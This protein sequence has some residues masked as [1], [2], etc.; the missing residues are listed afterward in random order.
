MK[1]FKNIQLRPLLIHL[2]VTLIYPTVKAFIS[3]ANRLH[4]FCDA[5]TIISGMLLICGIVY[6]LILHGD[7]ERSGFVIRRGIRNRSNEEDYGVYAEEKKRKREEAFNYPLFLGFFYF[8]VAT[9]IAYVF[10]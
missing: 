1:R 7:F 3:P 5:L 4:M 10:I 9:L 2:I 8:A 6:S